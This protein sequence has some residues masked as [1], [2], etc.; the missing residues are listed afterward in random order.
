VSMTGDDIG[1]GVA[2]KTFPTS[3]DAPFSQRLA[4]C[5]VV[6]LRV[7]SQS[8]VVLRVRNPVLLCGIDI[9]LN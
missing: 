4:A 5:I 6:L 1:E 7:L 3:G 8:S 2:C 9:L